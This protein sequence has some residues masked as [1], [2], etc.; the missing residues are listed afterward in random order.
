MNHG[1]FLGMLYLLLTLQLLPAQAPDTLWTRTYGG[2]DGE[3]GYSVQQTTDEGYIITGYTG[4]YGSG[5]S[6]VW[7]IKTDALG[8][9]QWTRTYGGSDNEI[10]FSVQQTADGG[11]I[12][13]GLTYSYG[14]G[15][16][17]VWL[18]K[19]DALGD[20]QWTK[21]FGG[22]YDDRGSF[23]QQT[24]DG[25]YI[26]AGEGVSNLIKTN[27]SGDTLWTRNF[28]WTSLS[29]VQTTSDGGYIATGLKWTSFPV[30]MQADVQII[31]TDSMGITQWTKTFGGN[32]YNIGKSVQ[33]TTDDGF[34]IT[35][36]VNASHPGN[37]GGGQ[38][39]LIKI[40]ASGDSSWMKIYDPYGRGESVH[41]T[42][43][44]GYIIAGYL[45]P[46][47]VKTNIL[48]DTLWT[49]T[50]EGRGYSGQQTTDGGY[51]VTGY[52]T[53]LGSGGSDVWL[54]KIAP[55]PQN[56][57]SRMTTSVSSFRLSPN[58]P[59]PF[60]PTTTIEFDLPKKS[61][62]SL[63]IFNIL[64]EEVATLLSASLLAG[65]YQ[66]EWDASNLASGVYLYRLQVGDYVETRKMILMR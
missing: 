45:G 43:D 57:K 31:K 26:V 8:D 16:R 61:E 33:Q 3:F 18:I 15:D 40:D 41:Q 55:D 51:I 52:T 5:G 10:G 62:V 46:W 14:A 20:T 30:W 38:T 2:S 7:L 50:F 13:T 60:N 47:L 53:S 21:T 44:G 36:Y 48:G 32:G 4:S 56:I 64:G 29:S 11:Y 58:Y 27:A 54:I 35:G 22:S 23:V 28:G 65:S 39:C 63:K 12:I 34:I 1:T 66:Y 49:K 59:N 37:G 17:A 6:D 42:T 24:N 19:T 25:G 9:T